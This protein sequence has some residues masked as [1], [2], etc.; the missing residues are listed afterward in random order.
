MRYL[1]KCGFE[2]MVFSLEAGLVSF[3]KWALQLS[4]Q[5]TVSSTIHEAAP[6]PFPPAR[7][8]FYSLSGGIWS[9]CDKFLIFAHISNRHL[10]KGN[11]QAEGGAN[12]RELLL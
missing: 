6:W 2:S 10:T 8:P 5:N 3:I 11:I 12:K 7:L 1:N 9:P 4:R